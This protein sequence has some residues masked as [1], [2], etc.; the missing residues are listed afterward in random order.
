[1]AT[2]E[3]IEALAEEAQG[4]LDD[5]VADTEVISMEDALSFWE[6]MSTFCESRVNATREDIKGRD[7]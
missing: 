5:L 2:E 7:E 4:D 3:V 6:Q 1:M